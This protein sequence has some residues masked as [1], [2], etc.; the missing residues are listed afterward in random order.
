MASMTIRNLDDSIKRRL[1]IRAAAHGKSMEAEAREILRAALEQENDD[2]QNLSNR[3]HRRFAE[4]G[5][6]DLQLPEREPLRPP[7][8]FGQ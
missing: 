1:R 4:V 3:I 5:G 6:V 2:S 7:P 8:D